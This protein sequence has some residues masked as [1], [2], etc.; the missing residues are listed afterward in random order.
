MIY[1][2]TLCADGNVAQYLEATFE[3]LNVARELDDVGVL[4]NAWA[5]FADAL[6][7]VGRFEESIQ[8]ADEGI[9][10][11]PRN[12]PPADWTL[13]AN[14]SAVLLFWRGNSLIWTG[15]IDEGLKDLDRGRRIAEEDG[16]TEI[17]AYFTAW[18]T[19]AH[20]YANDAER[21]LATARQTEEIMR[22]VGELPALVSHTHEA[23]AYAHLAAGRP[24]DA[25]EPA[26]AALAM[27]ENMEKQHA[28]MTATLLAEALLRSGD[29]PAAEAAA[30]EAIALCR[31]SSRACHEANAHGIRAR[32]LLRRNGPA[33]RHAVEAALAEAAA[34]IKRTGAKL[35]AP[36]LL[37]WRAELAAALGD[38]AA[39]LHLLR[40]AQ[41][42]YNEIGAPAHAARL[43]AEI[44]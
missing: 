37:E 11:F 34:L 17:I 7:W 29:L 21:A 32:A 19:Q 33:E 20:F 42:G 40:E 3:N 8:M 6:H 43:A 9:A 25:I 24:A 41:Q 30:D 35:I 39:R 22:A 15:R 12:L 1:D 26:R 23:F 4:A 31:R 36:A 28:G 14:P 44:G 18:S 13:G 38:N 10:R 16:T 2:R 5:Y 27:H